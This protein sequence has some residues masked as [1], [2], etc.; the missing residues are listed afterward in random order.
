MKNVPSGAKRN[1][2]TEDETG[3]RLELG[4]NWARWCWGRGEEA[5]SPGE[6]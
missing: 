1:N 4:K 6:D 5:G 2:Q 3:L